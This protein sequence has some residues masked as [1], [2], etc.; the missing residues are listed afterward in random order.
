MFCAVFRQFSRN[1]KRSVPE[2]AMVERND[3]S[4]IENNR[5]LTIV[6]YV[7]TSRPCDRTTPVVSYTYECLSVRKA[8]RSTIWCHSLYVTVLQVSGFR[9]A[10]LR[11][12]KCAVM[13]VSVSCSGKGVH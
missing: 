1:D 9:V 11:I 4:V 3:I 13:A 2:Y 10:E 6:E 5:H 7:V 12:D 8:I